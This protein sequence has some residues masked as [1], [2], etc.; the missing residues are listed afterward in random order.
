MRRKAVACRAFG[1]SCLLLR[2]L[3]AYSVRVTA[4][5]RK[6]WTETSMG[7]KLTWRLVSLGLGN[8]HALA[9]A[10]RPDQAELLLECF[11]A[12][13]CQLSHLQCLHQN[14]RLP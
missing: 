1:E 11:Q 5:L 3:L 4:I 7:E 13:L 6:G 2:I 8:V 12:L 9:L 10:A 14:N